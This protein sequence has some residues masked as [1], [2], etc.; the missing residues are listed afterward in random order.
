VGLDRARHDNGGTRMSG[1]RGLTLARIC[2]GRDI[3]RARRRLRRH[4]GGRRTR[5]DDHNR[6]CRRLGGH[7]CRCIA[8]LPFPQVFLDRCFLNGNVYQT[9]GQLRVVIVDG[10][11]AFGG[12]FED[13]I[14]ILRREV[15]AKSSF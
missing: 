11:N 2:G 5:V 8:I 1:R 6:A 15:F 4:T 7:G 9:G 3:M 10:F 14:L 13:T 12:S